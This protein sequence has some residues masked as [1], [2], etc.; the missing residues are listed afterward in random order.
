ME[1]YNSYRNEIGLKPIKDKRKKQNKQKK[2]YVK[3]D[4]KSAVRSIKF[5]IKIGLLGLDNEKDA[6][7]FRYATV[8]LHII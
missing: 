7:S 4:A 8:R 5:R 2:P 1:E 6:Y 3:I